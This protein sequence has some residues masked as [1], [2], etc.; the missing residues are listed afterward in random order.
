[1][2]SACDLNDIMNVSTNGKPNSAKKDKDSA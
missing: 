1:M 2:Y